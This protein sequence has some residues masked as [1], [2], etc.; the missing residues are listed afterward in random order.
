[1]LPL[2][3]PYEI[4]QMSAVDLDTSPQGQPQG[5]KSGE[6]NRRRRELLQLLR[7]RMLR[8]PRCEQAWLVMLARG[9]E[10]QTCKQCGCKFPVRNNLLRGE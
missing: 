1:M 3:S 9:A 7:S 5:I 2:V 6:D 10:V 8:C 4:Y